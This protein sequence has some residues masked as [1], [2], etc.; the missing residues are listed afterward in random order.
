MIAQHSRKA[1]RYAWKLKHST[2]SKYRLV[3]STVNGIVREVYRVHQWFETEDKKRCYFEGKVAET[4]I[5]ST[6]IGKRLPDKFVKKGLASPA[7]YSD[8]RE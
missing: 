3:L 1:N 7:L 6:F 8:K 2:V 5:R 4:S